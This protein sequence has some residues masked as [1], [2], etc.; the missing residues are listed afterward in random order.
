[1]PPQELKKWARQALD[2]RWTSSVIIC[3]LADVMSIGVDIT[4]LFQQK[5]ALMWVLLAASVLFGMLVNGVTSLGLAHYFINLTA[6]RKAK[7]ADLFFSFRHL[8]KAVWMSMVLACY[9][10]LWSLLFIIPGIIAM[11]RYSMVPYLIAEFPDLSVSEAME[12]SCRLMKGNK[13]RLF[14]LQFSFIGWVFLAIIGTWGIGLLWVTPY[15]Q[16]ADAAFYLE[17]TGR[18]GLQYQEPQQ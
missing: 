13:F 17:V 3:A 2:R 4:E 6:G 9:I 7:I 1:M 10:F 8:G 18:S 16:A 12:E 11:Y 14:A 5:S 15:M